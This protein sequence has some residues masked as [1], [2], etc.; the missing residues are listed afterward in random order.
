MDDAD[1]LRNHATRLFALALK[2]REDGHP[3]YAEELAQLASELVSKQEV[4]D[5][6]EFEA[7]QD[8][9]MEF[10]RM[11]DLTALSPRQREM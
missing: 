9:R 10:I 5:D 7:I 2:V 4:G 3:D 8:R 1:Q 6:D 11:A